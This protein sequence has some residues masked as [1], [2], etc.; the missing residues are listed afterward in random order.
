[1]LSQ[2]YKSRKNNQGFTLIEL[3]VVIAIIA[4][5]SS[6]VLAS[7]DNA[8]EKAR[9][10]KAK[11]E[12]RTLYQAVLRYN[13]DNNTWPSPCDNMDTVAEWN[14]AWATGY[15]PKIDTD[16]W[17]TSYFFD[18][19]PNTECSVGNSAICSAGPNK[20]FGSWNRADMT[21]QG[22]DVCAYFEPTC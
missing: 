12:V 4:I 5:L 17:G 22:D 6:V 15:L 18:G 11:S 20:A 9:V 10:A 13:F 8:R 16:P 7:L 3:L 2:P 19:C 21:A 1:M 14:G